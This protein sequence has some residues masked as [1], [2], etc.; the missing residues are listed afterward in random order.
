MRLVDALDAGAP[1]AYAVADGWVGF[2]PQPVD[3]ALLQG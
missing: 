3:L 2:L 1:A